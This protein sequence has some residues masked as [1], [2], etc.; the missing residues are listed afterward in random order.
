MLPI[1]KARI[2]DSPCRNPYD[3]IPS[4]LALFTHMNEARDNIGSHYHALN[5]QERRLAYLWMTPTRDP[6]KHE[7]RTPSQQ[8]ARNTR[9][10]L[11]LRSS[12]ARR[13]DIQ[14][15]ECH[16]CRIRLITKDSDYAGS[17]CGWPLP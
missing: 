17:R 11:L 10:K 15:K 8:R 6:S 1:H 5:R 2:P 4:N 3:T 16:R 12:G 13:L 7:T 14:S 9:R